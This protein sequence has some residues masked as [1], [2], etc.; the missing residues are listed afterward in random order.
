M[1][2][3]LALAA[4][5]SAPIPAATATPQSDEDKFRACLHLVDKD[6]EAAI[7][8]AGQWRVAGS[9]VMARQ[10]LGMAYAATQ[11]WAAA[12]TAFE[13]SAQAAG[14]GGKPVEQQAKAAG[15]GGKPVEQSAQAAGQGHH[16][17]GRTQHPSQTG[18]QEHTNERR[19]HAINQAMR[20]FLPVLRAAG[21]QHRY[22]GLTERPFGEQPA[23]QIGD[24]ERHVEGVS[25]RACAKGRSD[26]QL[27]R[28][29]GDARG[30]GQQG[31]DERGFDQTHAASVAGA[32][33]SWHGWPSSPLGLNPARFPPGRSLDPGGLSL[34]Q[35]F[36]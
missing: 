34:T 16:Q 19:G 11:R 4:A 2:Y 9:L 30:Q 14:Q 18:Q 17:P 31:D 33:W 5:M 20:G 21:R 10:C 6:P 22:K 32:P 13:Q 23:K 3:F 7:A 35:G 28:Q 27:T 12:M 15:Q 26:Q 36:C 1:T 8:M 24:A 25:H 29:T